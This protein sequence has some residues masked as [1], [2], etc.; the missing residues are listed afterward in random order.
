[1]LAAS[2]IIQGE[3]ISLNEFP[4]APLNKQS[5]FSTQVCKAPNPVKENIDYLFSDGMNPSVKAGSFNTIVTPWLL[6]IIPQNLRDYIPRINQCIEKGG[7][8]INTGSLAFFHKQAE[9]CYSEEE[10]CLLYTSPSP[11][12]QRGSR[13]P[14]SA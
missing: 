7:L 11:R 8:W 12:D 5:F 1:M 6:D 4:I 3:A 10:V 14:S 9:W 2:R 13:M